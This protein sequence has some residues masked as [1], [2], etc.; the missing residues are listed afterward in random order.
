LPQGV[1]FHEEKGI[2]L[3]FLL[4]RRGLSFPRE[5]RIMLSFGVNSSMFESKL[6]GVRFVPIEHSL[7]HWKAFKNQLFKT[8]LYFQFEGMS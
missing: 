1:I 6:Q 4:G 8:I 7:Y 3:L 5:K 2:K